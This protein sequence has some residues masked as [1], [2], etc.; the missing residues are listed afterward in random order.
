M[1]PL[2]RRM[3]LTL[4]ATLALG[5]AGVVASQPYL[6]TAVGASAQGCPSSPC[7]PIK[8]IIIMVKENRSFDNIFGQ[9]PGADGT[10]YAREGRA[11]T[12]NGIDS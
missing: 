12:E 5:G 7:S 6:G 3:L 10:M 1:L 11:Q 9:F 4:A 8:H 2:T